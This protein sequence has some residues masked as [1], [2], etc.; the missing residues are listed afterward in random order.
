MKEWIITNQ[1]LLSRLI[2]SLLLVVGLGAFFWINNSGSSVS[3]EEQRA[4]ERVA[5]MEAHVKGSGASSTVP[6]KI[7]PTISYS[8]HTKEQVRY[9]LILM[10]LLGAGALGYSFIKKESQ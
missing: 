5:R 2:G 9:M 7:T 10:M 1:I 4:A 3:L 6:T 8:E